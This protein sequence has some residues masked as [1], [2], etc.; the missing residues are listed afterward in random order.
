[1]T[2]PKI[3]FENKAVDILYGDDRFNSFSPVDKVEVLE[4]ALKKAIKQ[5]EDF[6]M[7]EIYVSHNAFTKDEQILENIRQKY[8]DYGNYLTDDQKILEWLQTLE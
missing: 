1:M 2:Q 8:E 5:A 3:R 7:A 6:V 4:I